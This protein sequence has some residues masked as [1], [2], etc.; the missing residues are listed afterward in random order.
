MQLQ[1]WDL[2]IHFMFIWNYFDHNRFVFGSE[3]IYLSS[4]RIYIQGINSTYQEPSSISIAISKN[5]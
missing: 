4:K 2:R 1:L 5:A 3:R